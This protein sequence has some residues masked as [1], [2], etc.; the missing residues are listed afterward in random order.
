MKMQLITPVALALVATRASA[1]VLNDGTDFRYGKG[2]NN[3]VD[4]QMAG[5]SLILSSPLSEPS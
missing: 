4:W 1:K 3:Q 5:T 2:F